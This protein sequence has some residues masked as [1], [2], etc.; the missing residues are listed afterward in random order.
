MEELNNVS[1]VLLFNLPLSQN[2]M[3]KT[4]FQIPVFHLHSAHP[5]EKAELELELKGFRYK[6]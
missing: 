2:E 5:E 4:L 6:I 1:L 3:Q